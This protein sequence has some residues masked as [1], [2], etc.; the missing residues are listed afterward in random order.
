MRIVLALLFNPVPFYIVMSQCNILIA[1][2]HSHFCSANK[3]VIYAKCFLSGVMP[4]LPEKE[5][6]DFAVLILPL[7]PSESTHY[8]PSLNTS[9]R[10]R[11][12]ALQHQHIAMKSEIHLQPSGF[13]HAC[14]G[15][16]LSLK[17]KKEH[18]EGSE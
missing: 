18:P 13:S 7:S 6:F 11:L 9:M 8:T 4:L 17:G 12:G 15:L 16:I 2:R 14:K 10:N 1:A 5:L 3:F